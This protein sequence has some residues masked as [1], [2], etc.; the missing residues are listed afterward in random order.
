MWDERVNGAIDETARQMT[1]G[2]PAGGAEF[3]RRVLARLESG[4][5]PRRLWR[6]AFVL[7]P[8]AAAAAIAVA[9]F[10]TRGAHVRGPEQVA[11]QA[12]QNVP[13]AKETKPDAA[14]GRVRGPERPALQQPPAAQRPPTP[15][16]SPALQQPPALQRPPALDVLMAPPLDVPPLAVDALTHDSIQID[17]LD[18]IAPMSIAPLDIT[19][20]QRRDQ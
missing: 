10:V 6:A 3:R 12:A 15:Q 13:L 8:I 9:V 18:A 11:T 5:A 1:E 2:S 16:R 14:V 4:D 17:H 19:D 20:V 7:P